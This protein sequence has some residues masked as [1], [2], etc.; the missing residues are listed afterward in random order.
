LQG[1]TKKDY[2]DLI[3]AK[4]QK[5]LEPTETCIANAIRAHSV[6]N[7]RVLELIAENGHVIMPELSHNSSGRPLLEF[8]L[9]GRNYASTFLGLCSKHDTEIFRPIE[10]NELEFSKPEHTFLLAYRSVFKEAHACFESACKIRSGYI[11]RV[12]SG[13]SPRDKPD[14]AG[15]QAIAWLCNASDMYLYKRK[16]DEAYLSRDFT[17]VSHVTIKI[18]DVSPS[19]AASALFSLDDIDRPD[20]VA[21]IALNIFPYKGNIMVLFSFLKEEASYAYQYIRRITDSSGYFQKYLISKMILQHCMNFVISPQFYNQMTKEQK[22]A[23]ETFFVETIFIN[24]HDFENKHLYLFWDKRREMA[25][26]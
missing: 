7:S 19:I 18:D 15:L 23:I 3:K 2:F 12:E 24:K 22:R 20:D 16:Y 11:Q 26:N 17:R 25:N 8:K 1:K 6:Q 9:V 21:R 5:C 14:K 4:Y 13:L 10:Q